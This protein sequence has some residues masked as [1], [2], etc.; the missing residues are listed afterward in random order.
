MHRLLSISLCM[1]VYTNGDTAFRLGRHRP[2]DC[3]A[4]LR[5][6]GISLVS[7]DLV[8]MHGHACI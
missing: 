4:R 5:R 3:I 8:I 7:Y 2:Q 1:H 6:L